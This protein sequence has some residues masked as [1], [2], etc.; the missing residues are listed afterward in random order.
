LRADLLETLQKYSNII[1]K[2]KTE[3]SLEKLNEKDR[4]QV[5]KFEIY[6]DFNHR[7][8]WLKPYQILALNR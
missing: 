8:E 5:S 2:V 6:S 1:S 3:K 4:S 7:I